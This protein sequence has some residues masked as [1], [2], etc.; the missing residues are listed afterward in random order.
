[1]LN[2]G[3]LAPDFAL[4]NQDGRTVRLSDFR[5]QKVAIFFFPLAAEFSLQCNA[6]ACAFRDDF[7]LL[8]AANT[9]VLGISHDTPKALKTWRD[10]HRL[11]YDLLSDPGYKTH[12]VWGTRLPLPD[13]LSNLPVPQTKRSYFVIDEDGR[14]AAAQVGVAP[15][16]SAR[17][18][19]DAVQGMKSQLT[20]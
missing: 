2:I 17:K 11:Q 13:F 1:M 20:G 4:L 3:D 18:A 8:R 7:D 10:G 16:E 15:T 14:I 19:L 12:K 9:V 6:Q 5:G